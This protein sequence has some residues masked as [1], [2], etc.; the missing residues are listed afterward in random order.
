VAFFGLALCVIR[1][2]DQALVA[3]SA[4]GAAAAVVITATVVELLGPS[5][6]AQFEGF[7]LNEPIGYVNGVAASLLMGLWVFVGLSERFRP[8]WSQA[9]LMAFT[10]MTG[11][12]LVLTQSRAVVPAV[13]VS[14]AFCLIGPAGRLRRAWFLGFA[15]AG[16]ALALP[17]LLDVFAEDRA[18]DALRPQSDTVHA[19]GT[20]ALLVSLGT[21]T[22]WAAV[23]AL[24]SRFPPPRAARLAG[25]GGLVALLATAAGLW[26]AVGDPVDRVD[27]AA[28]DFMELR[29]DPA[30]SERFTTGGGYRYDL[31][32]IA[33]NE[34]E[35]KPVAGIGLGNYE[36][37][38]V[39]E[40]RHS[41]YVRQPHS[42][43]LQLLAELGL[44][45]LAA[46]ALVV[47]GVYAAARQARPSE[48]S[49]RT[50]F[51][52]GTGVFTVWLVHTSVDWLYN[53]PA[54]TCTALLAAAALIALRP[55]S[56]G[57]PTGQGRH[58]LRLGLVA[59][60]AVGAA[61]V[62]RHWAADLYRERAE[63]ALARDPVASLDDTRASLQLNPHSL[64]S[65]YLAA[66]AY[67]ESGRYRA[68]RATLLE[69]TRLEPSRYVPWGL[70]GD[71]AAHKGRV[72]EAKRYYARAASLNPLEKSLRDLARDPT[73]GLK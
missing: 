53:L 25:V 30:A 58:L 57:L 20:A 10:T 59:L 5:G 71:L 52:A 62:G 41:Q 12:L 7:R 54:L 8:W 19:A 40:R 15:A 28:R 23:S 36:L 49:E 17:W 4:L 67:A 35:D 14:L 55:A 31:W 68:A 27:R 33:L 16:V 39:L 34:F 42:L 1:R 21:A 63:D 46:F 73:S 45:G 3:I 56:T 47:V 70:L 44:L 26:L 60:I 43:E 51:V 32:R 22:A 48:P 9:G 24:A 18:T 6:P 72:S 11:C 65:Y 66:A 61:A 29:V 37:P 69:A 64:E 50:V 38:F 2:K 13:L